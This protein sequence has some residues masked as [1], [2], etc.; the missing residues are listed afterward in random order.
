MCQPVMATIGEMDDVVRAKLCHGSHSVLR[1][2]TDFIIPT[3]R[4][5]REHAGD[6]VTI[7]MDAGFNAGDLCQALEAEEIDCLMRLKRND[8][9]KRMAAPHLEPGNSEEYQYFEMEYKAEAWDRPRRV[10]MVIP[11]HD[12]TLFPKY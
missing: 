6:R 9:L 3:V 1:Y 10:A 7:R 2:A 4:R 5:V 11:P 8:V 12:T